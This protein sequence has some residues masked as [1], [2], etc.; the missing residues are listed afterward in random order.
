MMELNLVL[1]HRKFRVAF[2]RSAL[3]DPWWHNAEDKGVDDEVH[4]DR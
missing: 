2:G 1:T 4:P 3:L